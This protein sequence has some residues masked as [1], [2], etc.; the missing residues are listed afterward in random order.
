M[1][2]LTVLIGLLVGIYLGVGQPAWAMA[3]PVSSPGAE[4]LMAYEQGDWSTAWNHF[5]QDVTA[6]PESATAL[7]H[8]CLTEIQLGLYDQAIA[9]CGRAIELDPTQPDYRL[10]RGVALYRQGDYQRALQDDDWVLAANRQDYR[11]YYNRGLVHVA[12]HDFSRAIAEFDQAIALAAEP[13]PLAEIYD[14]RGLAQL[15]AANPTAAI[16]DFDRALAMNGQDIR[17]LFNRGCACHQMGRWEDAL[18]DLNQVL[19]L[20]P[21][22]ARTYL[23]RGLWRQALGDQVGA[24]ADLH[25]AADFAQSQGQP[26]LHHHILTVLNDWQTPDWSAAGVSLG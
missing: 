23:N 21:S 5:D 24:I 9:D 13:E 2:F 22:H 19:A 12:L 16:H 14:D 18:A 8:R 4:G 25:Q 3:N 6:Y 20:D 7:E 17:A 15:M 11:G 10:S 26:H 1:A